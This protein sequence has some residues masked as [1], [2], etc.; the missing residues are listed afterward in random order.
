MYHS[1]HNGHS[2]GLGSGGN[3]ICV[4]CGYRA[5]HRAGIPCRNEKCP[6]CGTPL[7]RE[8]SYHHELFL[9]KQKGGN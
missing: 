5:Q 2:Q 1:H 9:K 3:C 6:K 4:K 7:L 8:N